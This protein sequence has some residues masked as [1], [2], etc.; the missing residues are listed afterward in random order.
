MLGGDVEQFDVPEI[1]E[2]WQDEDDRFFFFLL[3]FGSSDDA[4]G[5]LG[6]KNRS[7]TGS[8]SCGIRSIPLTQMWVRMN[9]ERLQRLWNDFRPNCLVLGMGL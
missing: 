9:V 3:L 6:G 8:L 1:G 5:R 4:C 7:G 2:I